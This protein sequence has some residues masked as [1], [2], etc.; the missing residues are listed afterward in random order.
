MVFPLTF[1]T[2]ILCVTPRYY[3]VQDLE[4]LGKPTITLFDIWTIKKSTTIV[5][6]HKKI[7]E[8][9]L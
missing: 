1:Y 8:R 6:I 5:I 9:Q 7:E 4:I 3:K 2:G